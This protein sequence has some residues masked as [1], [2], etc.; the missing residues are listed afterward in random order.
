MITQLFVLTVSAFS[1]PL[2]ENS[3]YSQT[4]TNCTLT[5]KEERLQDDIVLTMSTDRQHHYDVKIYHLNDLQAPSRGKLLQHSIDNAEQDQKFNYV[6]DHN[7]FKRLD[8][9]TAIYT[10]TI[11]NDNISPQQF[12][13]AFKL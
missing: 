13:E 1:I 8:N 2:L 7:L 4:E 12:T 3:T 10:T 6:V 9:Q 5:V 11:A